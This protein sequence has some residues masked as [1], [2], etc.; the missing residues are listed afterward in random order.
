[1]STLQLKLRLLAALLGLVFMGACGNKGIVDGPAS[2]ET[3]SPKPNWV[4]GKPASSVYFYGVGLAQKSPSNPEYLEVAKKNALN[5]LASEIEVNVSSSSILYTLERDYKFESEFSETIRTTTNKDIAGY[6]L[7]DSWQNEDQY[8]VFY[9]L[10]RA[11]YYAAKEREKRA[12]LENAADFYSV[13]LSAWEN[14]Q[15]KSAFDL[16]VRALSILKPYWAENNEYELNGKTVKLDN[17]ALQQLQEM[18]AEVVLEVRPSPIQLNLANHYSVVCEVSVLNK[19]TQQP[20]PGVSVQYR[21]RNNT[22]LQRGTQTSDGNGSVRVAIDQPDLLK[23]HHQLEVQVVLSDLIDPRAADADVRKIIDGLPAASLTVPVTF[24]RPVVY[25]KSREQ[26]LHYR[27][28][29]TILRDHL[30]NEL[31]KKGFAVARTPAEANMTIHINASTRDG[32]TSSGF[33]LAYLDLQVKLTDPSGANILYEQAFTDLKGA[34]NT[35]ERAGIR[36]FDKG[37]DKLDRSFVDA[38]LGVVF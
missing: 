1:M 16:Q 12:A 27:E 37:Q 28:Q 5:D 15:L 31:I 24:E 17:R 8:W 14:N 10:N 32:G 23:Q 21:Y 22:G 36:A 18:A 13:G 19:T 34:S 20:L 38:L 4:S 2:N 33:A 26:N 3:E 29:L 25:L 11:D 6:E 30:S 9:R 35:P 7:A